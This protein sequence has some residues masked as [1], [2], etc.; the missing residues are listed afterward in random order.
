ML[1][2][3]ETLRIFTAIVISLII[4]FVIILLVTDQPLMAI[5]TF[6]IGPLTKPRY[7]GNVIE[8]SIPLMFS[9][10]ATALL[11]QTS[12]FNLGAEGIFYFSGLLGA[13]VGIVFELPSFLHILLAAGVSGLAGMLVMLFIGYVKAKW[14]VSELVV[15]LMFNNILF[16]VGLFILNYYFRE[17]NTTVLRS[18]P[19]NETALL[20]K[21]I[22]GT[23]IH[24]GIVIALV[25]IFIVHFFLYKTK[26]GYQIRMVGINHHFG[27]H[28]GMDVAKMIMLS[29]S[30]AG[31]IA[32]IGGSVEVLG[33]YDSFRWA[34]LPG[35]GFDGALVAMLA[36]NKPINVIYSALFLAYIRIGA[37]MMSRAADVPSEMIGIMQA[38]IILLISGQKFLQVYKKRLLVK[39]AA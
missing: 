39:G 4:A 10:V 13:I 2:R 7:I 18:V 25:I 35:V 15:S 27:S 19:I 36:K 24:L 37:D 32:G 31:I 9:G 38:I 26:W 21:L 17:T 33:M 28:M 8:A 22:P 1:K 3:F 11:F 16:G 12:L 23:R 29:S 14:N 34:A 5:Q 30:I 20:P 6:I